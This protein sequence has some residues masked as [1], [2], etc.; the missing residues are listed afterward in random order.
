MSR[1]HRPGRGALLQV[2]LSRAESL[3]WEQDAAGDRDSMTRGY[4]RMAAQ[5]GRRF[6]ELLDRN[7]VLLKVAEARLP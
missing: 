3:T 4:A 1:P 7:G 2:S 6:V 5:H